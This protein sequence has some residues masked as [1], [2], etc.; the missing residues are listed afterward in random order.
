MQKNGRENMTSEL[1]EKEKQTVETMVSVENKKKS[2]VSYLLVKRIADIGLSLFVLLFSLPLMAI[3][4]VLV[5]LESKGP[6]FYTQTRVG[7]DGK[8]FKVYK[9]RTMYVNSESAGGGVR[10]LEHDPR[11][12][13]IGNLVRKSSF[14]E[15]PQFINVLL[16]HMSIIGPRP[17]MLQET[18]YYSKITDNYLV[19]HLVRPGIT[20]W[21]QVN[22]FHGDILTTKI[23]R[24]RVRHDIYYIENWSVFL[25]IQIFF[26][27]IFLKFK[28]LYEVYKT[29][30]PVIELINGSFLKIFNKR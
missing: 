20:G 17:H 13:K 2:F 1:K 9:L 23:M 19:R 4:A 27:T 6:V 30:N 26:K 18:K 3:L 10:T 21:A 28:L 7:K 5:K 15:F 24:G 14:D 22:G 29:E 16:G 25:D 8:L 11:I 12:T